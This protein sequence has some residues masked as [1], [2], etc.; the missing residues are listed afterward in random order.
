MAQ[1]A[2]KTPKMIRSRVTVDNT[3]TRRQQQRTAQKRRIMRQKITLVGAAVLALIILL[4]VVDLAGSAGKIH[5][6]VEVNG[7]N[8]GGK[9][10]AQARTF[11]SAEFNQVQKRTITVA[12]NKQN[13]KVKPADLGIRYGVNRMVAD[14]YHI[15]RESN[16]FK[17]TGMRFKSYFK[18]QPVLLRADQNTKKAA[19]A[20][21]PI[22]KVTDKTPVNAAVTLKDDGSDFT[23]TEGSDGMALQ[24][25]TL[26]DLIVAAG[27]SGQNTVPAPVKIAKRD[28]TSQEA[29]IAAT[30]AQN[31]AKTPITATYEDKN[32][33]LDSDLL[34]KLFVFKLS[35]G[36]DKDDARLKLPNQKS[37]S[38]VV[39]VPVVA[40]DAIAAN[41]IPLLGATVGTAPVPATFSASN[42][43]VTVIPSKNGLGADPAKMAHDL[44]KQMQSEKSDKSVTVVTH[45]VAPAFTTEKANALG[46]KDRIST[47]TTTFSSGNAA[48]V[49]NITLMTK[50]LDGA[51]VMPGATFS[52]NGTVGE[53]NAA[54]GYQEAGAIVDGQPTSQ[55]GGGICQVN[56]TLFNAALLSGVKITERVNHSLY[57]SSYPLGRDATVS[58]P[59]PDFKFV[60]TLDH[61]I[62]IATSST[63]SSVTISFYGVDPGYKVDL[64]SATWVSQTPAPVQRVNDPT[65][66]AGTEVVKQ[67]GDVG[68]KVTF[69][70]TV[71]KNGEQV[72]QKTFTSVYKVE[73]RIIQVGTAP[74]ATSAP[75]ATP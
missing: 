33:Q 38:G 51:I 44:V 17:A 68:G 26:T 72:F 73:P 19:A 71:T 39:L 62:L 45:E 55:V 75:A 10:P 1:Q 37:A 27:I 56:T 66:P 29:G 47:Y 43:S 3:P 9:T 40:T 11:L 36:L 74:A 41:V 4:V 13:W 35:N 21:A 24:Q 22:T 25:Q 49:T 15:G 67:N 5:H 50:A 59:G 32:W 42:G 12:Y 63:R 30:A 53:A 34:R 7:L 70:Q 65:L 57:I 18:R 31:A 6:G 69:V 52:L 64:S 48:R 58:W 28:I 2:Q 23:V 16:V 60:N 8:L 14:A 20:Y 61:A 54:K 46:I